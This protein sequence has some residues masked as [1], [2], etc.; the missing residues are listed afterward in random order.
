MLLRGRGCC[1]WSPDHDTWPLTSRR[2]T[3]FLP[4]SQPV[5]RLPTPLGIS[6]AQL[7]TSGL[8]TPCW[9]LLLPLSSLSPGEAGV[10]DGEGEA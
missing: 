3:A 7:G 8:D 4:R 9:E 2:L 1:A 6:A 10:A 5:P